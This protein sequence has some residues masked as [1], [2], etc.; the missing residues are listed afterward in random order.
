MGL[1]RFNKVATPNNKFLMASGQG[2]HWLI[3]SPTSVSLWG[4]ILGWPLT[5]RHAAGGLSGKRDASLAASH[6]ELVW[7]WI[8]IRSRQSPARILPRDDSVTGH[9]TCPICVCAGEAIPASTGSW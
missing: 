1:T 3:E 5:L 2:S 8:W 7:I 4:Y 6:S 9:V